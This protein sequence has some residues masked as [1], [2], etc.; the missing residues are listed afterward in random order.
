[1]ILSFVISVATLLAVPGPTNTLLGASGATVGFRKSLRLVIGEITGYL[2]AIIVL[3]QILAPFVANAP[4][5]PIVAKALASVV[6]VLLA[7]RLWRHAGAEVAV[8]SGPISVGQVF[9]TTLFN[10][11]AL[12]FAFVIF[13]RSGF[14]ETVRYLALFSILV[15]GIGCAWIALGR[16]IGG[17]AGRLATQSL[18]ARCAAVALGVFATVIAG[19]AV[20]SAIS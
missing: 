14:Q 16:A 1:M 6:L 2:L 9:V 20:A 3:M 15:I 7:L 11:K 17:S 5:A 12:I 19:S 18:I 4:A 8:A 10:P 13:P